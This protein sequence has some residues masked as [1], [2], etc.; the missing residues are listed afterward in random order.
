[1]ENLF[2]TWMEEVGVF[3]MWLIVSEWKQF[4]VIQILYVQCTELIIQI[5]TY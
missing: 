3:F 4:L 5:S 1:M 2:I